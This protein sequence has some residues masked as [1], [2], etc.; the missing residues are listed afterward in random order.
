MKRRVILVPLALLAV[1][2]GLM[3]HRRTRLEARRTRARAEMEEVRKAVGIYSSMG[4]PFA[5]S[6]EDLR[7][8]MTRAGA[9]AIEIGPDPW[10]HEYEFE[11]TGRAVTVTCLGADGAP[12]GE[13]DD[14]DIVLHW[15]SPED[16]LPRRAGRG[17]RSA[18]RTTPQGD[19]HRR[20]AS[21]KPVREASP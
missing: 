19:P 2:A 13:G 8:P 5:S 1:T 7:L 16:E 3:L 11:I 12:G 18:D 21:R 17:R 20:P 15:P 4:R 9:D 14:E 6:L 10:G